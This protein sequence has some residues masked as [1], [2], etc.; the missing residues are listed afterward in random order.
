MNFSGDPGLTIVLISILIVAAI[1]DI[2][3][4]KIPN[5]LTFP[6]IIAGLTFHSVSNGW[7]GLIF[8]SMGLTIGIAIGALIYVF[9]EI[10]GYQ[11]S[12]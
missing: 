4:Q 3:I 2:R 1:V 5:L 7:S 6:T 12:V 11:F 8:S 10:F 9:L